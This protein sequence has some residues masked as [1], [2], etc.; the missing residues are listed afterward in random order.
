[1]AW[2]MPFVL[3]CNSKQ[4]RKQRTTTTMMMLAMM[5]IANLLAC[6]RNF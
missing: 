3:R 2:R 1:M 5:M 4:K 6:F